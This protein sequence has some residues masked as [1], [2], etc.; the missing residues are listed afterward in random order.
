MSTLKGGVL[1]R[2]PTAADVPPGA[3]HQGGPA[4]KATDLYRFYRAGDEETLALRGVSVTLHRGELLVVV[5]PSGSGK[6]TLLNCLC[7]LDEPSGGTVEVTGERMSHQPEA[8]R[9]RLRATSVGVMFQS[10]SLFGHL[11]VGA[12][13]RL[14]K[15][16]APSPHYGAV[17]DLLAS[18]GIR[19]RASAYPHQLSGGEAARA[20]LAV[21][22]AND[23]AVV[24]ADEPTGELDGD[25]ERRLL[26]LLTQRA[27]LGGAVIVASHSAAV[28]RIADRVITLE[29]GRLVS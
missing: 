5:G 11:T 25:S 15:S 14:A 2:E 1:T 13:V 6:S 7:G 9:A 3:G 27:R 23:P 20:A 8:T 17:D 22:L 19:E 21:A 29:D 24:L 10:D 18:L 12:N 4:L 16:L 26:A 28:R